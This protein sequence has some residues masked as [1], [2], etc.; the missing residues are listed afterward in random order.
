MYVYPHEYTS[1]W[2][3]HLINHHLWVS[4]ITMAHGSLRPALITA[5]LRNQ[6]LHGL[7]VVSW[8]TSYGFRTLGGTPMDGGS[9]G[10]ASLKL[11]KD[12]YEKPLW[13]LRILVVWSF[14]WAWEGNSLWEEHGGTFCKQC[15]IQYLR[16]ISMLGMVN[17]I[18]YLWIE[19]NNLRDALETA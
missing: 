11:R 8:G 4:T 9:R 15:T 3:Y 16:I 1:L 6:C 13:H 7:M 12:I 19:G 5:C 17:F 10:W 18:C 14:G 2:L